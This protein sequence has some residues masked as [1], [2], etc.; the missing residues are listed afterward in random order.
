MKYLS[1]FKQ[2]CFKNL[3]EQK[4]IN[5][6][7][8][9]K[10]TISFNNDLSANSNFNSL[11]NKPR[12]KN[13]SYDKIKFPYIKVNLK[14]INENSKE[15]KLVNKI[16]NIAPFKNKNNISLKNEENKDDEF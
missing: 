6:F 12:R 10:Y 1:I 5:M 2:N 14:L 8:P 4:E 13:N 11:K 7:I 3:Q 15:F 9:Q 16:N